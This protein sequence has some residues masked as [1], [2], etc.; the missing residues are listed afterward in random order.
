LSWKG[1]NNIEGL[2][3]E[4]MMKLQEEFD[5]GD[6]EEEKDLMSEDYMEPIEFEDE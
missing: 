3:K 2:T 5:T 6:L 4:T 1:A